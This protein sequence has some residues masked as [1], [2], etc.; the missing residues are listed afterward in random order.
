MAYGTQTSGLSSAGA[1]NQQMGASPTTTS[2]PGWTPKQSM[3]ASSRAALNAQSGIGMGLLNTNAN[4]TTY[5]SPST[6][7]ASPSSM[8]ANAGLGALTPSIVGGGNQES[9]F[10]V[11]QRR[12]GSPW[13]ADKYSFRP[14]ELGANYNPGIFNNP[15][16]DPRVGNPSYK[17]G[18][19]IDAY[20]AKKKALADEYTDENARWKGRLKMAPTSHPVK[21]RELPNEPTIKTI[22]TEATIRSLPQDYSSVYGLGPGR[23]PM[24]KTDIGQGNY[25]V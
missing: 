2:G 6:F 19:S 25:R 3:S 5:Q 10:A 1:S 13:T 20:E 8:F 14:M 17:N 11:Q 4:T 16:Y 9:I 15:A 21:K 18:L 23:R 22:E 24:E 12:G 7:N